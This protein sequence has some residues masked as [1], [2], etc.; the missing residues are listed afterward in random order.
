MTSEPPLGSSSV[1]SARRTLSAGTVMPLLAVD[2]CMTK[3]PSDESS[4]TSVEIFRLIRPSLSTTGVK[5]RPT[6]KGLNS[7]WT[8]PSRSRDVGTGNSPPARNFADSP[9][10][11]V[12]L[13]SA[14]VRRRPSRSSAL[15][16]A[17]MVPSLPVTVPLPERPPSELP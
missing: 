16:A 11:A 6:P 9:E 4:L 3:A 15:I 7:S 2:P 10:I 8:L 13:G 5:F 1:V 17:P 14:S 12:R